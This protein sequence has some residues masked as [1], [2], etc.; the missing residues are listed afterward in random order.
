MLKLTISQ[1]RSLVLG[2]LMMG[3]FLALSLIARLTAGGEGDSHTSGYALGLMVAYMVL[4]PF[5][6]MLTSGSFGVR[7]ALS[8]GAARRDLTGQVSVMN[9]VFCAL[10]LAAMALV[11][12]ALRIWSG[13]PALPAAAWAGMLGV[14]LVGGAMGAAAGVMALRYPVRVVVLTVLGV[15]AV[16]VVLIIYVVAGFMLNF[17]PM[18]LLLQAGT[19]AVYGAAFAVLAAL[20]AIFT[21]AMHRLVKT[22]VVS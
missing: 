11:E 12:E 19:A 13:A 14:G 8:M 9:A 22:A 21:A 3:G 6:V 10:L 7:L 18:A 5:V 17:G 2:A 4:I 16:G 20:W 15:C 1:L